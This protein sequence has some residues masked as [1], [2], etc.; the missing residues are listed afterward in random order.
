MKKY[1]NNTMMGE[2]QDRLV[3]LKKVPLPSSRVKQKIMDLEKM[4]MI[5][6]LQRKQAEKE[7]KVRAEKESKS[8]SKEKPK[9][10]INNLLKERISSLGVDNIQKMLMESLVEKTGAKISE[11]DKQKMISKMENMIKTEAKLTAS[12]LLAP[13]AER[14][15]VPDPV[16]DVPEDDVIGM[17]YKRKQ[18]PSTPRPGTSR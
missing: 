13:A 17:K 1:P 7:K 8:D 3:Q 14:V 2:L 4:L 12:I 18:F 9:D 6:D 10:E 5:S 16:L 15:G 11:D